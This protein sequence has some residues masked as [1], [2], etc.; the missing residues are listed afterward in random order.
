LHR[1]NVLSSL[2]EPPTLLVQKHR[3][4]ALKVYIHSS[5]VNRKVEVLKHL[6]TI[7]TKHPGRGGVRSMLDA[8]EIDGP[9]GCYQCVVFEPLLTSILHFQATF[10]PPSLTVDFL[11][12]L[13]Q[14]LLLALDYLHSE[15]HVIHTDVQAKNIIIS[16][17]DHSIFKEWGESEE[18]E[19][20]PRKFSNGNTLYQ[21]RFFHRKKGWNGYGMPLLCDFGDARIGDAHEGLI[22]L[23]IYRARGRSWE[24]A[25]DKQHS[26]EHLLAKMM[27]ILGPPSAKLLH[28]HWKGNARIPDGSL[29]D[30]EWY[31]EGDEKALFMQFMRKMLQWDPDDRLTA[32]EL[33]MDPW[34][35]N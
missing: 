1:P 34:L 27:A 22:Q 20:T 33:L 17:R 9:K 19:P 12:G 29:E 7:N 14:Q 32:R 31:L 4:I 18:A 10:G 15:A 13:Q 35:N 2:L 30:S 26:N 16:A 24:A 8:F 3:Y 6:P 23:D 21:S 25:P 28:S 5:K 11:K